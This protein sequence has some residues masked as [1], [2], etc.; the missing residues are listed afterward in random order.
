VTL[1]RSVIPALPSRAVSRSTAA[2][3][4]VDDMRRRREAQH[5]ARTAGSGPE[6]TAPTEPGGAA[7]T[8]P[9]EVGE[10]T[11][12]GGAGVEADSGVCSGCGKVKPVHRGLIASHQKGL[13]KFCVGSR[14][15][16][17]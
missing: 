3:G 5:R 2:M 15:P 14:K 13:G 7:A 10:P 9:A 4:K 17:A 11:A 16:P 1:S 6:Q 12:E 8:E